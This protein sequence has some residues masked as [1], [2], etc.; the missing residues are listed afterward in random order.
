M[1]CVALKLSPKRSG[2]FTARKRIPKDVRAEYSRLYGKSSEE[3][4]TVGPIP[5][6]DARIKAHEWSA[7]IEM[8]I[9]NIRAATTGSGHSLSRRE[10][11]ALAGEWYT[12]FV[13]RYEDEPGDPQRW[14]AAWLNLLDDLEELAPKAVSESIDDGARWVW[15]QS[16][17]AQP[18]VLPVVADTAKTHSSWRGEG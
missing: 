12:W 17:E 3:W 13:A 5:A 7:E 10:A 18:H 6:G 2:G 9:A 1:P 11:L 4:F 8:R 14:K 15:I 16:E